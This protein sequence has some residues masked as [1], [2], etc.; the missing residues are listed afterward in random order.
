M[1]KTTFSIRHNKNIRKM[2]YSG[3]LKEAI[4]KAETEREKRRKSKE[5]DHLKWQYQKAKKE[6]EK[7]MRRSNDLDDFIAIA[8]QRLK[9]GEEDETNH[10]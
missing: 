8:R 4:Q 10:P 9:E 2:F 5:E 1:G 3:D 6:L 7:Y